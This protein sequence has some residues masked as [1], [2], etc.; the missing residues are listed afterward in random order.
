MKRMRH[1]QR[2]ATLI[3]SLIMLVLL[4][5]LAV[6]SFNLGK[7]SLQTVGNM[8]HRSEAM[9]AAQA[10]MEQVISTTRLFSNPAAVIPAASS[11]CP[12]GGADNTRC[13]DSNLDGVT[14]VTV[15]I[16]PTPTC[17]KTEAVPNNQFVL[18]D[19]CHNGNDAF[20]R[21][22][23][24]IWEVTVSAVDATTQ[25]QYSVTQGMAALVDRNAVSGACPPP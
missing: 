18:G 3:I 1:H 11:F 10:T 8:Q 4:T 13:I 9:A 15:T 24:T 12:N 22:S 20:S 5:L 21:C 7:G 25:A 16:I 19:E 6:T 2:G 14:D 17:I 23:N